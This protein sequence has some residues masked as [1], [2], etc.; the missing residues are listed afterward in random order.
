[1]ASPLYGQ[2]TATGSAQ[3]ID[4]TQK[5]GSCTAF[6]IPAP[7]TNAGSVFI[8]DSAVTNSTGH[9]LDPGDTITYERQALNTGPFYQCH[10]SDFFVWIVTSGDKVTWLALP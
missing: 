7:L 9:Q 6:E 4:P 10:P 1:M 8:G 3:Q 2:I 5:A